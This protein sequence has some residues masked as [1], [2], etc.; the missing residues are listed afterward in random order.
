MCTKNSDAAIDQPKTVK[1]S[2]FLAWCRSW[3]RRVPVLHGVLIAQLILMPCPP[4]SH[5]VWVEVDTDADGIM[6][7]G[8]DDGTPPPEQTPPP[9]LPAPNSDSDGDHLTNAEEAAAGSD[10]YKPDTDYD[11]LTDADEIN[12]TGT[13]PAA[14]DTT[15][16]GVSDYNEFYGNYSVDTYLVGPGV[17]P[18]DFDGDGIADPVDPDALSTTKDPD[19][20]GDGVPDSQDS[21]PYTPTVWND[22]NGN[23]INDDA[24]IHG[25]R[26]KVYYEVGLD[27]DAE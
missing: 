3:S 5:A 10:P 17:S 9:E 13:D 12:L 7:S 16:D 18:Y 27:P 24:E 6:D 20:E 15:G 26:T 11:G 19:R 23:G 21:D 2:P 25:C 4:N 8:Y 14:T 1:A 22:A